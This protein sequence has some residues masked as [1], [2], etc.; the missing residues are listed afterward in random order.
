MNIKLFK[1]S[2]PGREGI[3][4]FTTDHQLRQLIFH[5]KEDF[6]YG[7]NTLALG[8]LKYPV[9]VLCYALM[10]NH[11]HLLL[12]G[13]YEDCKA[14]FRWVLHRLS[15]M[16][17]ARY[18][19]NGLLKFDAADVQEI[20]DSRMLLNEVAYL[21]RNPY[22]ARIDS[23]FSSP[24]VP[25]EVYFN[26]YIDQIRGAR[27]PGLEAAKQQLGTH[28][29]IPQDWEHLQGRIMNKC[30]VD[31]RTVEKRIGSG[32][33]LFDRIRRFDLES[34]LAQAHGLEEQLT[35]TDS[36]MQEKILAICR[37]EWHVGSPHQLGRKDLLQLA[38][39]LAWRFGATKKQLSRLLGIDPEVLDQAL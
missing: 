39:K 12:R 10:D 16:L 14:Y 25:F 35:F 29:M 34:A 15:L 13:G 17:K 23:P 20:T 27:F 22:K 2:S 31:Y 6:T 28:M 11:L 19:V 37:N 7:V 24:W 18:G 3:Y 21:L 38:R 1:A 26:P 36:E 8:T 30:F 4:L 32:L 5:D 33:A 9:F